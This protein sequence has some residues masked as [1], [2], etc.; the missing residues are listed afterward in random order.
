MNTYTNTKFMLD[1][2]FLASKYYEVEMRP[3]PCLQPRDKD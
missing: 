1:K 2:E 3:V